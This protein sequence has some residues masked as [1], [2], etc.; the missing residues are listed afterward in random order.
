MR[1][2]RINVYRHRSNCGSSAADH[3][4]H[5]IYKSFPTNPNISQ[6]LFTDFITVIVCC[7]QR[8]ADREELNN[9]KQ[10]AAL[11]VPVQSQTTELSEVSIH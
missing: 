9:Q 5:F 11:G 10:R 6:P 1:S 7:C 2:T 4:L 8:K 3:I